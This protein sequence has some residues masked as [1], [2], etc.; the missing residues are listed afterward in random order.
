MEKRGW[1]LE[2]YLDNY[3][4]GRGKNNNSRSM[5]RSCTYASGNTAEIDSIRIHGI[6]EGEK[7]YYDIS[8][9]EKHE[10]QL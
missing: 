2:L 9:M 7:Q 8:E 10:I 6:S 5:S 1:K 3:V 4:I